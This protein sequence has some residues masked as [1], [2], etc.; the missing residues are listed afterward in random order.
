MTALS[1]NALVTDRWTTVAAS[2]G[3][4]HAAVFGL[5]AFGLGISGGFTKPS[6]LVPLAYGI[7]IAAL[8]VGTYRR[9]RIA[10]AC[11]LLIALAVDGSLWWRNRGAFQFVLAMTSVVYAAGLW[12]AIAWHRNRGNSAAPDIDTPAA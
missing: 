7:V 3:V 2:V 12:S 11:L 9:S 5:L 1:E 10:A 4:A 6:D 8:A